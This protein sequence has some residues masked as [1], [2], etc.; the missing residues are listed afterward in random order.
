M[1]SNPR[2]VKK[3]ARLITDANTEYVSLVPH[4]ANQQPFAFV[5]SEEILDS[6]EKD[7][8]DEALVITDTQ[9]TRPDRNKDFAVQKA[10]FDSQY[11][12]KAAVNTY[13]KSFGFS[14]F[15]IE[16]AGSKYIAKSTHF[17][18]FNTDSVKIV[19][20]SRQG[21]DFYIGA[22]TSEDPVEDTNTPV[23][24]TEGA[25]PMSLLGFDKQKLIEKFDYWSAMWS[26]GKSMG[27]VLAEGMEDGLPPGAD[28]LNAAFWTVVAN[29]VR[30][31]EHDKITT[32]SKEMGELIV[33]ILKVFS[34]VTVTMEKGAMTDLVNKGLLKKSEEPTTP[35]E[36]PTATEVVTEDP[37]KTEAVVTETPAAETTVEDPAK[38]EPV[39]EAAPV[40]KT[41][42]QSDE[43]LAGMAKLF[44]SFKKE[45][46]ESLTKVTDRV[47][48]LEGTSTTRKSAEVTDDELLTLVEKKPEPEVKRVFKADAELANKM[49]L[50]F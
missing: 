9:V 40:E 49:G 46:S 7:L 16:Q 17:D 48:K 6:I 39:A 1:K 44:D 34:R 31:N 27:E 20:G 18:A 2:V 23:E 26:S 37:A 4:G 19:K 35:A 3:L 32:A 12:D 29:A 33:E 47:E 21:V 25:A 8:G 5:K 50:M 22:Y 13:L 30:D 10:E 38:T 15:K 45:V 14:E 24:K 36:E 28:E 42:T 43:L 41:A 11:F